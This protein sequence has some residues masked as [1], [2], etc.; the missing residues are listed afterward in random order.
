MSAAIEQHARA[1]IATDSA[2]GERP[3]PVALR[4]DPDSDPNL[5]RLRLPGAPGDARNDWL[6]ARELLEEGLR[7]PATGGDVRIWPCGRVQT[8]I[9]LHSRE[10]TA[11]VWF[12]S[13]TL[14]RFLNRIYSAT[15]SAVR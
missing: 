7:A 11:V 4:Y 13:S 8:V 3:V 14:I 5:V 9:E 2:V 15:A 10:G 6:F 12:D 1:H